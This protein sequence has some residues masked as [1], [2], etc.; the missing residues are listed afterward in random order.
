MTSTHTAKDV[1]ELSRPGGA[2]DLGHDQARTVIRMLRLLAE[3]GHPVTRNHGLH[4]IA[5]LGIDRATAD[6]L[7]D[8][9]T[10][11]DDNGD[12]VELGLTYNRYQ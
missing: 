7:L 4:K 5:E 8:A 11:R 6:A 12:V 1:A 10:E 3:E 9:W 2:L